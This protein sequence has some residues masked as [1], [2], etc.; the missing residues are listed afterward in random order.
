MPF[1]CG[2]AVVG[3]QHGD[4]L[5]AQLDLAQRL[6]R[7][8][9]RS[10]PA[11]CG[12]PRR[13]GGAGRGRR[14]GETAGRRRRSAGWVSS[15]QRGG[16]VAAVRSPRGHWPSTSP[17]PRRPGSRRCRTTAGGSVGRVR[18]PLPAMPLQDRRP[19]PPS[20][21]R[22]HRTVVDGELDDDVGACVLGRVL[23]RL[24]RAEATAP[25]W[26]P[27]LPRTAGEAQLAGQGRACRL[28]QVGPEAQR[29][30]PPR[31]AAAGTPAGEVAQRRHGT[32]DLLA[33]L[34]QVG[35]TSGCGAP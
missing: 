25:T 14:R 8:A 9:R 26:A 11:R 13:S 2:H 16:R 18:R 31:R 20:P 19:R 32:V 3:E 29:R 6:E 7:L 28:G 1:I 34:L 21:I 4:R 10:R 24:R 30:R 23:Q 35:Q 22:A 12:S 33:N 17:A 27:R 5:A 15:L